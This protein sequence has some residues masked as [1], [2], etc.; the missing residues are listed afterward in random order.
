VSFR[1]EP[2]A[3]S[4]WPK[5]FLPRTSEAESLVAQ[6]SRHVRGS[7][8]PTGRTAGEGLCDGNG[9]MG[10]RRKTRRKE[11]QVW[12]YSRRR[13]CITT[14]YDMGADMEGVKDGLRR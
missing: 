2:A 14:D 3:S 5:S 4:I 10:S 11:W 13:V 6:A 8:V 7:A 1:G 12:P 9:G